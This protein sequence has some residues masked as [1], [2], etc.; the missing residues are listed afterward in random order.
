MSVYFLHKL[1]APGWTK[2]F[3]TSEQLVEE[4]RKHICNLCLSNE[5]PYSSVVVDVEYD[6]KKYLCKDIPTLLSTS[7]GCEYDVEEKK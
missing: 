6:G 4:L 7:C 5:E 1:S 3:T 2:E